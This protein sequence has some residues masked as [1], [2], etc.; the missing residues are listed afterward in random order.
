MFNFIKAVFGNFD[1]KGYFIAMIVPIL[2][3]V[4]LTVLVRSKT[5]ELK[6]KDKTITNL[7]NTIKLQELSLESVSALLKVCRVDNNIV[8]ESCASVITSLGKKTSLDKEIQAYITDL[9]NGTK[10]KDKKP[11]VKKVLKTIKKGTSKPKNKVIKKVKK[12]KILPLVHPANMRCT[13][14]TS[15]GAIA[16][17]NRIYK[18][19]SYY[20]GE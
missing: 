2:L 1:T 7:T 16:I 17:Y 10:A 4:G 20:N 19:S 6:L 11:K 15:R 18:Q 3:I 9:K 14:T 13:D 12:V 8:K 5:S